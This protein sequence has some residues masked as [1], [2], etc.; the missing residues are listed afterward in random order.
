MQDFKSFEKK[1]KQKITNPHVKA[2]RNRQVSKKSK[3]VE[4][5]K[6][7]S[8]SFNIFKNGLSTSISDNYEGQIDGIIAFIKTLP[9]TIQYFLH[10]NKL[11]KTTSRQGYTMFILEGKITIKIK[12]VKFDLKNKLEVTIKEGKKIIIHKFV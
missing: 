2:T 9:Q 5:P 7:S 6:T 1:K 4:Y 10:N 3:K 12:E 11:L 8:E